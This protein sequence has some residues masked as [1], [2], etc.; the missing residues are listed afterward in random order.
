M[1]VGLAVGDA[2]GVLVFE[3]GDTVCAG[4][5]LAPRSGSANTAPA[6]GLEHAVSRNMVKIG[7]R[8]MRAKYISARILPSGAFGCC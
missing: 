5:D 3:G 7:K 2:V 8:E 1:D 6:A 4:V